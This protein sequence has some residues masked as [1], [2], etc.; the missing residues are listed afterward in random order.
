MAAYQA[1]PFDQVNLF[2]ADAPPLDAELNL[3]IAQYGHSNASLV[4]T[5]EG[6]TLQALGRWNFIHSADFAASLDDVGLAASGAFDINVW[7]GVLGKVDG[8]WQM[9]DTHA[10]QNRGP[11]ADST[12]VRE[13]DRIGITSADGLGTRAYL[14]WA[15]D[16]PL[17]NASHIAH[18]EADRLQTARGSAFMGLYPHRLDQYQVYT[19]A[20][21]RKTAS[22]SVWMYLYP[23][24]A[25]DALG[26]MDADLK[27]LTSESLWRR[28]AL[29]HLIGRVFPWQMGRPPLP[30]SSTVIDP[31]P[32]TVTPPYLPPDHADVIL[33]F[34]ALL[35]VN[36][37]LILG[38][39][40]VP[41]LPSLRVYIVANSIALVRLAD[42]VTILCNRINLSTDFKSW[43]WSFDAD[44]PYSELS[45][46]NLLNGPV[47][48]QLTLNGLT[49]KLMAEQM[50]DTR[51]FGGNSLSISGRSLSAY[52]AAPYAPVQS[53]ANTVA[54]NAAQLAD[55]ALA[56][57]G[58]T[59][60]WAAQDW[61]VT[62]GAYSIER[63]T[64]IEI[65]NRLAEAAGA[66]AQSDDSAK[67]IHVQPVYPLLPWVWDSSTPNIILSESAIRSIGSE[68]KEKPGYNVVNVTGQQQ[69]VSVNAVINGTAGDV[70]APQIVDALCTHPDMGRARAMAVLGDTGKQSTITLD[71]PVYDT[72]GVIHPGKLLR[73]DGSS[74]WFGLTRAVRV[75]AD[76]S[77]GL[78]I[79]Q[80]IEL[81]RH[82]A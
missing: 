48:L 72:T 45:K 29:G 61:L 43:C 31:V 59:M 66:Y 46:F 34:A 65:I 9:A 21:H 52:L 73:I 64:P 28:E 10:P 56:N 62:A 63:L 53:T 19:E 70:A 67:T 80:S 79:N 50:R 74:S 51:K 8:A 33:R 7:R 27:S 47:E 11:W 42:N 13:E 32:P 71:L 3:D 68:W 81:E 12:H 69:G 1:P 54:R 77:D 38:G 78:R 35:P 36:T 15:D 60:D 30:G 25:G 14:S 23:H 20:D 2:L 24:R 5:L 4:V 75:S 26:W 55:D 76:W 37:T 39:L 40:P 6:V 16:L 18:T 57:T 82:H 49:W 22:G 41:I 58:W 17:R 44:V